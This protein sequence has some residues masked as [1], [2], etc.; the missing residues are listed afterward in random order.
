MVSSVF[1]ANSYQYYRVLPFNRIGKGTTYSSVLKVQADDLPSY[2]TALSLIET[3]PT[4]I[5]I[6]WANLTNMNYNG[7]DYPIFY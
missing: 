3:N 5:I 1:P 4:N 7:G 2:M 6:D